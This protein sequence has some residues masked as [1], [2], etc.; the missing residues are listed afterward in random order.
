MK[1]TAP[2]PENT[3]IVDKKGI[4]GE[5]IALKLSENNS[6]FFVGENKPEPS[7]SEKLH[8]LYYR[9][10][11]PQVPKVV[12]SKIIIIFN[13]EKEVEEILFELIKAA[14]YVKA[15]FILA[16][17]LAFYKKE[18][19]DRLLGAYNKLFI[20]FLGDLFGEQIYKFPS[21]YKQ[22]A[23]N[24]VIE[25]VHKENKIIISEDGLN[26]IFPVSV[27]DA[28]L[29]IINVVFNNHGPTRIFKLFPK[30]P[31]TLFGLAR[32][33]QKDYPQT[34]IDFKAREKTALKNKDF[35]LQ[36]AVYL[37]AGNTAERIKEMFKA[38]F[39]K[40]VKKKSEDKRKDFSEN[41]KFRHVFLRFIFFALFFLFLPFLITALLSLMGGYQLKLTKE[42]LESG[43]FKSSLESSKDAK[44]FIAL[45]NRF[46]KITFFEIDYVKKNLDD[47]EN[48]SSAL[49]SISSAANYFVNVFPKGNS[50]ADEFAKNVSS[51]KDAL[52][53]F[54][55]IEAEKG[56]KILFNLPNPFVLSALSTLDVFPDIF[57]F[58][59]EKTYAIFFQNN[60]ELRPGGG[61]IGSYG[62]LKIKKGKIK[63]FSIYDV[64]DAD[65]QL[66]GHIEPPYPIRRYLPSVHWYL[67]D[68]N[69][70]PDFTKGAS[71]SAFFL[72]NETGE[73]VD[74]I[75]GVDVSFVKEILKVLGP[76]YVSDYNETVSSDNLYLLAQTHAE[77]EFFP[78]S[79]QKKDFLRSLFKAI[80]MSPKKISYIKLLDAVSS[81]LFQKHL[82]FAFSDQSVQDVFTVNKMS[83]ALFD[84][85]EEAPN[86]IN[87]FLGISE[88]NLGIN[89]ANF[90]IK[91][92]VEQNMEIAQDGN[93]SGK[94][95]ISYK[96]LSTKTSW[97]GGDYKNYLRII[98]PF[99]SKINSIVIDGKVQ[100]QTLAVTSP[101][102]YEAKNFLPPKELEVEKLEEE[103]KTIFGFLIIVPTDAFK[104]IEIEY[105]LLSK[106]PGG[107]SFAYDLLLFKQPGVEEYPYS[108][109]LTHPNS[110]KIISGTADFSTNFKEDTNLR[111][112]F[113]KQ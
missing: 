63:D 22:T 43:D 10:K 3:L 77:K 73:K 34:T 26:Y 78:G 67:R 103:G 100:E 41:K 16:M 92:K 28:V 101:L 17:P 18:L 111:I 48:I 75:V 93:V 85:R 82:L 31:L 112:D 4:L 106:I 1:K 24:Q 61:F 108:F 40:K 45:A 21:F 59:E 32:L 20:V 44:S 57:G 58:K 76:V 95:K 27:E 39:L 30:H 9:K 74:G 113:S 97:P 62:I 66:K 6:V 65:G 25:R 7:G 11:F 2:A 98:L 14:E 72:E 104:T 37:D 71:V 86:K 56:G 54:Q 70:D 51:L 55:K 80:Q 102:I 107:Q 91:R 35:S 90:F 36:E 50:S 42:S 94:V 105:G 52:I 99:G 33:I 89:K 79:T 96:N 109:S 84:Q 88:A 13:G 29:Q 23:I 53:V 110:L 64:Y 19:M 87:D 12:F 83:S 47:A 68:S 46:G 69:F 5:S 38:L 81:S 8:Y 60:M 15:K 49:Y